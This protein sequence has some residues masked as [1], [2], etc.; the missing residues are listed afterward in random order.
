M[1]YI[2]HL[3]EKEQKVAREF[4]K[5]FLSVMSGQLHASRFNCACRFDFLAMNSKN[6]ND[7]DND[8]NFIMGSARQLN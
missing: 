4:Q 6:N 8:N 2:P 5:S 7:N 3:S 1:W